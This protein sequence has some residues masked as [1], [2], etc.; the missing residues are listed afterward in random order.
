MTQSIL[1]IPSLILL[2]FRLSGQ[3]TEPRYCPLRIEVESRDGTPS[4][5]LLV[6][7]SRSENGTK[8]A[9][10]WTDENGVVRF[11]DVPLSSY[12]EIHVGQG[13]CAVTISRVHALWLRTRVISVLY[14]PCPPEEM[15]FTP[16]CQVLYRVVDSHDMPL[17]GVRLV[18]SE[19]GSNGETLA[20][21]D[22]YGRIF[23]SFR[24]HDSAPRTGLF[25]R[26]GFL[27]TPVTLACGSSREQIIR[28]RLRGN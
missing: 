13:S 23:Q 4:K 15:G 16:F 9:D 21:S 26:S 25:Q 11:C 20:T 2:S 6:S 27:P 28:L 18:L 24:W 22:E 17:A 8:L 3:Q 12:L 14:D 10:A 5:R 19:A 7:A 1:V